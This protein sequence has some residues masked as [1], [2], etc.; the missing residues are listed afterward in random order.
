MLNVLDSLATRLIPK[1]S[2]CPFSLQSKFCTFYENKHTGLADSLGNVLVEPIYDEIEDFNF[3]ATQFLVIKDSVAGM[4]DSTGKLIL[5]VKYKHIIY[6]ETLFEDDK[7]YLTD[8]LSINTTYYLNT[9]ELSSS[10]TPFYHK[11]INDNK[12]CLVDSNGIQVSDTFNLISPFRVGRAIAQKDSLIGYIDLTGKFTEE[13]S[14]RND[15][16]IYCNKDLIYIE[17]NKKYYY[18]LDSLLNVQYVFENWKAFWGFNDI[19]IVKKGNYW[20]LVRENKNIT[21]FIYDTIQSHCIKE[22]SFLPHFEFENGKNSG[23]RTH[24]YRTKF[25][26]CYCVTKKENNIYYLPQ[27]KS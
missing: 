11:N 4:V 7:I 3:E 8:T 26:N 14:F 18:V 24:G 19:F 2:L 20:G 21:P 25:L 13:Q 5:P 10:Y 27:E 15:K 23:F 16:L 1:D 9:K 6:D 17:K 22:M 12:L